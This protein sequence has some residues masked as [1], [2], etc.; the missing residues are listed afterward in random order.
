M[1]A[2]DTFIASSTR[3]QTSTQ[4]VIPAA[5]PQAS[6]GSALD[7]YLAK[8]NTLQQVT[9]P[10]QPIVLTQKPSLLQNIGSG[11]LSGL[12]G[13]VSGL[14]SLLGT[15]ASQK[16]P[17]YVQNLNLLPGLNAKIK[18]AIQPAYNEVQNKLKQS[19]GGYQDA[20]INVGGTQLSQDTGNMIGN[21]V[22][23]QLPL[24]AAGGEAADL[25]GLPKVASGLFTNLTEESPRLA[26][27]L[28]PY[29][30]NVV[31]NFGA[32]SAADQPDVSGVK[33]HVVQGLKDFGNSLLF[34][35]TGLIPNKLVSIPATATIVYGL[36]RLAG[37]D[38][39][40]SIAQAVFT[41][42]LETLG[43]FGNETQTHQ[44]AVKQV[45]D[46]ANDQ[47]KN[48]TPEE[49]M[50]AKEVVQEFSGVNKPTPE[51]IATQIK[52]QRT[53]ID[54]AQPKNPEIEK[55][56]VEEPPVPPTGQSTFNHT[57]DYEVN[58]KNYAEYHVGETGRLVV[59]KNA[60]GYRI[61]NISVDEAL[62][63]NKIATRTYEE[64]NDKSI[65]DTGNPLRSSKNIMDLSDAGQA[66]WKSLVRD[67]K[68]QIVDDYYQMKVPEQIKNVEKPVD[69]IPGT[70]VPNTRADTL[71][72][73]AVEKKIIESQGEVPTHT[74]QK[75]ADWAAK[76]VDYIKNNP[77]DYMDVALGIKDAPEGVPVEAIYAA[78]E[79]KAIQDGDVKAILDLSRSTVPTEAG[80]GLKALDSSDPNSPVKIV[81]DIEKAREEA[82]QKT[83]PKSKKPAKAREEIVKK[84]KAE[85]K[86]TRMKL[87]E[88][89][90]LLESLVC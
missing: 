40:H 71:L 77:D 65:Q 61:P 29:S 37:Q 2:L 28:V 58:G 55:P 78:A 43:L 67:G 81:R 51:D 32:F 12:S 50:Q 14:S 23:K 86:T 30:E 38:K 90:S 16:P 79:I 25:I 48:G 68:A 41:G 82:A 80:R 19:A 1:S 88:A 56:P 3:P 11:F 57:R 42:A 27:F 74:S 36:S 66:L 54:A 17:A 47:I 34:G 46:E 44:D 26:K 7:S 24:F 52:A 8:S 76:S 69:N 15:V 83:L 31:K 53:T 64:I 20:S 84:G 63:K 13:V 59:E 6:S 39:S 18:S 72:K 73:A 89:Q 21:F 4:P 22:G 70:E 62:Q 10:V 5:Q 45:I 9:Q 60:D 33:N 75:V 35:A 85:V 87:A 49:Q